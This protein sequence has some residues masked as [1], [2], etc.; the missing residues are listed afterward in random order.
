MDWGEEMEGSRNR[1]EHRRRF[2][3]RKGS[4]VGMD[5]ALGEESHEQM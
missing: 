4:K 1:N 3:E 2:E 5:H